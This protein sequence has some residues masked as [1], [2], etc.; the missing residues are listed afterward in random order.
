MYEQD[1]Y[2]RGLGWIW[3]LVVLIVVLLLLFGALRSGLLS[4]KAHED[5]IYTAC[6]DTYGG[7]NCRCFAGI[8]SVQ[9]SERAYQSY[10]S[11]LERD[12]YRL[13]YFDGRL[14]ENSFIG[15][16]AGVCVDASDI[17]G[18]PVCEPRYNIPQDNLGLDGAIPLQSQ[19]RLQEGPAETWDQ[20]S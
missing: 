5:P 1:R 15:R 3:A 18:V 14:A 6:T 20:G 4:S 16:D 9:L 19:G 11:D 13:R 17:C 8:L 7:K 2:P 10:V 12:E